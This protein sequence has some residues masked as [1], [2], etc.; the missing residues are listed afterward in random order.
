MAKTFG[1]PVRTAASLAVLGAVAAVPAAAAAQQPAPAEID[2][3]RVLLSTGGVGYF[4][5]VAPVTGDAE[6]TLRRP[7]R[8]RSTTC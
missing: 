3:R 5:Y 4:E 7:A 8:T 2:L 6:L 1:L